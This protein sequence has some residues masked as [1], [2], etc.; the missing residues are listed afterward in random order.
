[1]GI[2][3]INKWEISNNTGSIPL[4]VAELVHEFLYLIRPTLILTAASNESQNV[5][6]VSGSLLKVG[7][8]RCGSRVTYGTLLSGGTFYVSQICCGAAG[9]LLLVSSDGCMDGDNID[10]GV[11]SDKEKS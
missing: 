9:I 10:A 3:V 5:C 6:H 1:V 7:K 2:A 11:V 4:Y 8:G